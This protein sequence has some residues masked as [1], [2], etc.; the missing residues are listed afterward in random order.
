MKS[1]VSGIASKHKNNYGRIIYILEEVQQ[2]YGYLPLDALKIVS[3]NT[4]ISLVDIYGVATFYKYFSLKKRGK[5]LI[6][7]CLGTACHV[8]QG[9]LIIKEF[10]NQLGILRGETTKDEEF[11]LETVNCLG[12]CARG[13]IVVVDGHYFSNVNTLQVKQI[14]NKT[15]IGLDNIDINNNEKI[16]PVRLSCPRCNHGLLNPDYLIDNHPSVQLDI[17]FEDKYGWLR[18]SS[19]Y[20]S[21][22]IIA[23][24]KI[25]DNTLVHFFCPHC[26]TELIQSSLCYLCDAPM[27][28]MVIYGKGI[29]QIC[30]R[31]G[32]KNRTLDLVKGICVNCDNR[33]SCNNI[34]KDQEKWFCEEYI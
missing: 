22:N 31:H 1:I 27:V 26:H 5:H 29:V 6:S 19:L 15:R 10:E 30:S 2:K 23:E 11:T 3:K 20:G 4:G 21:N 12:A 13:P 25:P 28:T 18:L 32:C 14:I 9:A 7:V 34:S 24:H 16:F 8:R 33:F 17:S